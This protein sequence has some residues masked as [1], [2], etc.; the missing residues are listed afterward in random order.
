ML[1]STVTNQRPLSFSQRR[2]PGETRRLPE[3][4]TRDKNFLVTDEPGRGGTQSKDVYKLTL[5]WSD[6]SIRG[7]GSWSW[8]WMRKHYRWK[9]TEDSQVK[10]LNGG[11]FRSWF[12]CDSA[13]KNKAG[14]F[15]DV[16]HPAAAA[17][18]QS[19]DCKDAGTHLLGDVELR[20]ISVTQCKL[21]RTR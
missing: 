3:K 10:L 1:L 11:W 14:K 4:M 17:A 8:G 15:H 21:L 12:H 13:S 18:A 19:S 20:T 6:M 9:N 16:W 2:P 7:A 5:F